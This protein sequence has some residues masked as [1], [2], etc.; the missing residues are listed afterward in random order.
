MLF[1]VPLISHMG[2][3]LSQCKM[4][5]TYVSVDVF[6]YFLCHM[7]EDCLCVLPVMWQLLGVPENSV[8]CKKLSLVLLLFILCKIPER[9]KGSNAAES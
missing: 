1:V 4:V 9:G 7:D 5:F 8:L 3:I 2:F 6:K